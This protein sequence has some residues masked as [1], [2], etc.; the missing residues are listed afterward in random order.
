MY[1]VRCRAGVLR[2]DGKEGGERREVRA[3]EAARQSRGGRRQRKVSHLSGHVSDESC[4]QPSTSPIDGASVTTS[5]GLD[6]GLEANRCPARPTVGLKHMSVQDCSVVRR[7]AADQADS[8]IEVPSLEQLALSAAAPVT[9]TEN[10]ERPTRALFA[11][12]G[13]LTTSTAQQMS[14]SDAKTRPTDTHKR[15]KKRNSPTQMHLQR[16]V[17]ASDA[18]ICSYK[19][20]RAQLPIP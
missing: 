1:E 5:R 8:V 3:G 15:E 2:P 10:R 16:V 7:C 14:E 9:E 18:A 4:D 17:P 13:C 20:P 11:A 6:I 12:R 19:S